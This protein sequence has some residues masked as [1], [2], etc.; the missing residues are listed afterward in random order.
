MPFC[1]W[2]KIYLRKTGIIACPETGL[3]T[4]NAISCRTGSVSIIIYLI[5]QFLT[6]E[7]S[8]SHHTA[9]GIHLL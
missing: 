6:A 3:A 7:K 4:G 5:H 1:L 9:L 8:I 2:A